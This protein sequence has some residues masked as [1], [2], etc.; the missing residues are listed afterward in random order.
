MRI[1]RRF[2]AG[3]IREAGGYVNFTNHL[4]EPDQFFDPNKIEPS[5]SDEDK[6]A[7]ATTDVGSG[8]DYWIKTIE[9]DHANYE[10]KDG[11]E[12]IANIWYDQWTSDLV[13]DLEHDGAKQDA[14]DCSK[15]LSKI[16]AK[17]INGIEK[18]GLT[19]ADTHGGLKEVCDLLERQAQR[20]AKAAERAAAKK[21]NQPARL[22]KYRQ[23]AMK[24]KTPELLALLDD[25]GYLKERKSWEVIKDLLDLDSEEAKIFK[26]LWV[27][28][29]VNK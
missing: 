20:D 1:N 4:G 27:N 6:V 29:F 28:Q 9:G 24:A 16:Q 7:M 21:A 3:R 23:M 25:N 13:H 17:I 12:E 5:M 19:S 11:L 22:E 18:L 15:A 14:R 26:N 2:G 10:T 8:V